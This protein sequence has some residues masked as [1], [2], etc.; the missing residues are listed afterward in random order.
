MKGIL[1]TG[2][3]ALPCIISEFEQF[4]RAS[5]L[6]LNPK[7]CV[8]IPLALGDG[9]GSEECAMVK[10]ALPVLDVSATSFLVKPAAVYLGFW[11]GP[12]CECVSWDQPIQIFWK[13]AVEVSKEHATPRVRFG[14][15]RGNVFSV[16]SYVMQFE[17]LRRKC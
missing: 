11:I 17:P 14:R 4:G 3:A 1:V 16:L 10:A 9:D 2:F 8:F 5:G 13:R 7:K 6:E 12:R 15:Y